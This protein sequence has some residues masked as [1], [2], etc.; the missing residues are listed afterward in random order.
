MVNVMNSKS[1]Y[2]VETSAKD[3]WV[4]IEPGEWFCFL[5]MPLLD[6]EVIDRYSAIRT[7]IT[8]LC[9]ERSEL[10]NQLHKVDLRRDKI[11][12]D[13]LVRH[14]DVHVDGL[15]RVARSTGDGRD[16]LSVAPKTTAMLKDLK[17]RLASIEYAFSKL[18]KERCYLETWYPVTI[19][20]SYTAA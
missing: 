15:G 13:W 3:E 5:T 6:D 10:E 14:I 8:R 1:D 19:A 7:E 4:E 11:V 12:G 9:W 20:K 17:N 16:V 2:R 18:N